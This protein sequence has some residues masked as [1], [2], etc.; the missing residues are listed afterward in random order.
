[1]P[2]EQSQPQPDGGANFV[3]LAHLTQKLL[4]LEAKN[5]PLLGPLGQESIQFNLRSRFCLT[6]MSEPPQFAQERRAMA[7][8]AT[9]F[10]DESRTISPS[11]SSHHVG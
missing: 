10:A 6:T 2:I 1:L 9:Q 8:T 11:L 3:K 4:P 5:L 7:S